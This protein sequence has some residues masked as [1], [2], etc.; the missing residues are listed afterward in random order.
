MVHGDS[1]HHRILTLDECEGGIIVCHTERVQIAAEF[2]AVTACSTGSRRVLTCLDEG[3]T[4]LHSQG[5][6]GKRNEGS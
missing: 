4:Q 3:I 2:R 5:Y 1:H 6:A